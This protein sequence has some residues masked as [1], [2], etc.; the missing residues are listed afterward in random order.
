[1]Y[2]VAFLIFKRDGDDGALLEMYIKFDGQ[3]SIFVATVQ[4]GP[5][6]EVFDAC[7]NGE[8]DQVDV[9]EDTCS[10]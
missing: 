1:M 2:R 3:I 10:G 4:L 5:D 9:A 7:A 8:C 6:E